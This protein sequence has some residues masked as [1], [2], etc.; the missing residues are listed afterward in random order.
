MKSPWP[1]PWRAGGACNGICVQKEAGRGL[2]FR[3]IPE[4]MLSSGRGRG[5]GNSGRVC[6]RNPGAHV[7]AAKPPELCG[8]SPQACPQARRAPRLSLPG[9][10]MWARPSRQNRH[11]PIGQERI[12][13]VPKLRAGRYRRHRFAPGFMS[14]AALQKTFPVGNTEGR[15]Q[16]FRCGRSERRA[17]LSARTS[18]YIPRN[19]VGR[20]I[21]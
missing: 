9:I 11:L 12:R 6:I 3:G 7:P 20:E 19:T 1:R 5:C 13:A 18:R 17:G 4:E 16:F 15:N 10:C 8:R 14:V 2:F 21:H